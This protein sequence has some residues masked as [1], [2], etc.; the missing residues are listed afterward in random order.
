MV[1]TV[2]SLPKDGNPR[3]GQGPLYILRQASALSGSLSSEPWRVEVAQIYPCPG[4][5]AASTDLH[6]SAD[7]QGLGAGE[8]ACCIG[9]VV[10]GRFLK[11]GQGFFNQE[12]RIQHF[13]GR[14]PACTI[15]MLAL[16][17]PHLG[18]RLTG[19]A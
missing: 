7:Q 18:K 6:K 15:P 16:K 14:R 8:A 2:G 1:Y 4:A 13:P 17:I 11:A 5:S 19:R 10:G 3:R 12:V 9:E